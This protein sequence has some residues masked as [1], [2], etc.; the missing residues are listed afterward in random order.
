MDVLATT[1]ICVL[2]HLPQVHPLTNAHMSELGSI[3]C[4]SEPQR[5]CCHRLFKAPVHRQRLQC[6][7]CLKFRGDKQKYTVFN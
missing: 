5:S 6:V 3:G 4:A 2:G 1:F 7:S